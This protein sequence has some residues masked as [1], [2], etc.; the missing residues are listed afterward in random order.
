MNEFPTE[1][2]ST[3]IASSPQEMWISQCALDATCLSVALVD[4]VPV[5]DVP[6]VAK[7]FWTA[8]L[9]LEIVGVFPYVVAEDGVGTVQPKGYPGSVMS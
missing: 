4:L 5:D 9:V 1:V 3:F 8:V 6:P 7:V 2:L